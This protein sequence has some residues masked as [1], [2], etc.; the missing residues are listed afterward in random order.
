MCLMHN[1]SN[2]LPGPRRSDTPASRGK[3]ESCW[4]LWDSASCSAGA[5]RFEVSGE[6]D[7]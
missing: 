1:R 4:G 2:V 5:F 6:L 7:D 3:G